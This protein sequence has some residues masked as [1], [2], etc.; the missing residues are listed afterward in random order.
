M[1]YIAANI[2]RLRHEHGWNQGRVAEQLKISVPAYSKI[3]TG[4]TDIN[5]SRLSQLAVL[6]QV[7]FMEILSRPGE[8]PN[9]SELEALSECRKLLAETEKELFLLQKKIIMLYDERHA[10]FFNP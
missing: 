4:A 6:F 10:M 3:E 8:V 1:K 7:S 2:R 5:L 9:Q